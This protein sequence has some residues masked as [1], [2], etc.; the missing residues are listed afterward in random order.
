[1]KKLIALLACFSLAVCLNGC[2]SKDSKDESDAPASEESTDSVNGEL[3]KVEGA[4]AQ[5]ASD[6][7]SANSG[8]LDEQ[9]PE[10]ALG[11][12]TAEA[13]KDAPAEPSG[14]DLGSPNEPVA[15][16]APEMSPPPAEASSMP[17]DA[18][19]T[20]AGVD[21][22]GT[23]ATAPI[24]APPVDAPPVDDAPKVAANP[25][26]KIKTA[27]FTEGG[28]L[29]NAVYVARPKD[30]FKSVAKMIYGDEK[31]SK[32]LKKANPSLSTLRVGDKVYYNSPQRSADDQKMA[33]YYEDA[34]MMPEL[35]VAQEGDNLRKVAKNLMGFDNAWKEVYATNSVESNKAIPAGTE[36]RYWKPVPDTMAVASNANPQELP[37]PVDMAGMNAPP[38]AADL[39]PPPPPVAEMPPPPPIEAAMPPPPPVAELPPPPPEPVAPPPPP[40]VKKSAPKEVPEDGMDND[41]VMALGGGGILL[42]GLVAMMALRKRKQAKEMAAAFNETQVGS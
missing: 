12:K 27:P 6:D 2:T 33:T 16:T 35:Y 18:T 32:D 22:G 30:N 25:Y 9:L 42:V 23:A 8:F 34:G 38:P 39:P 26:Q 40:V 21:P 4:D 17:P 19:S 7:A 41:M 28:Q 1:M 24:D 14:L 5:V 31:K 3:E 13:G 10:D 15:A 11:E 20:V 36:L 29:L 37:P